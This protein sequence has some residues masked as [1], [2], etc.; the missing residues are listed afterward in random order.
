MGG[1][2]IEILT[3]E[4]ETDDEVDALFGVQLAKHGKL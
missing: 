1:A 2:M 4:S 3:R